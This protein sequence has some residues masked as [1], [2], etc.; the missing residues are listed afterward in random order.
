MLNLLPLPVLDGGH[1]AMSIY[2]WIFKSPINIKIMEMLQF[3]CALLLISFMV[4]V[5]WFDVGDLSKKSGQR[6][7]VV[8]AE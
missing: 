8:F 6:E 7:P 4:Y 2:E 3:G 1:I 5:T